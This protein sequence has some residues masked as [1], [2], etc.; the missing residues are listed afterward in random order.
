[1]AHKGSVGMPIGICV[2]GPKY[3]D[4]KVLAVMKIIDEAVG[5]RK[6]PENYFKR[7]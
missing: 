4:E 6:T 2:S 3:K 1:M 7:E 5:F